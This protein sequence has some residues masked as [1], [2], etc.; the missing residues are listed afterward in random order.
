M[1]NKINENNI[2]YYDEV[3][4]K[5][6]DKR[7]NREMSAELRKL[8]PEESKEYMRNY[9][10]QKRKSDL[11][12]R[13]ICNLRSRICA[14]LKG[15][16]KSKSTLKLLGCSV[17]KLNNYIESKFQPGM[18]FSNYGKWHIDHIKPCA[19]FDLSKPEEQKKCFHYTNLQPL[20]AKD[21]LSK[22]KKWIK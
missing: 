9:L 1:I 6:E 18:S 15:N 13:I 17:E 14:V 19:C 8:F 22:G 20:W 2:Y 11:N 16:S 4:Q 21:N 3:I 7:F 5:Y 12:F 10:K